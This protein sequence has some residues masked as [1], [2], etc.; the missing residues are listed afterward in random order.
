MVYH[1][2][3]PEGVL[4]DHLKS[5][6][7][8]PFVQE[9]LALVD[10]LDV[11]VLV[12][13]FREDGSG[14]RPYDPYLMAVS[15]V[16]CFRNGI[17]QPERMAE[18]C[19][20]RTQLL[21][22]W[23]GGRTPKAS[24][25]RRFIT[26]RKPAWQSIEV[27]VLRACGNA[28]LLDPSITATDSSPMD[29]PASLRAIRSLPRIR[30]AISQT[31]QELE[32]LAIITERT[33]QDL[34]PR[35]DLDLLI[36][37]VCGTLAQQEQKLR[38]RLA[39]LR[40]AEAVAEQRM[41]ESTTRPPPIVTWINKIK[42]H[43]EELQRMI[44]D[45]N[46]RIAEHAARPGRRRGSLLP[47]EQ[48]ARVK[49]KQDELENAQARLA[50]AHSKPSP[51]GHQPR[52]NL[53]EPGSWLLLG[54]NTTTWVQGHLAMLTVTSAQI[55][56][57]ARFH[58]GG[59]D[60]GGLHPSLLTAADNCRLAG[61]TTPMRAH[62]ADAG[63]ASTATFT[64]PTP[65]GGTLYV[66]VTNEAKQTSPEPGQK[67]PKLPKGHQEMANRMATP[68]GKALYKRRAQMVEPVFSHLFTRGGRHLHTRGPAAEIELIIMASTHN[69]T[70]YIRHR[71]RNH[72][73]Q[74][75]R[76]PLPTA[77]EDQPPTIHQTDK[78]IR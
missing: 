6:L 50:E 43:E 71:S 25:F 74:Q 7:E 62:L 49:K 31:Q 55:V 23:G 16:W 28:G 67:P 8:D 65:T 14:G 61:V 35:E 34:D 27:D 68:Q 36:D 22:L 73:K 41:Q 58:H 32:E 38:N 2:L 26:G 17:R 52:A 9:L 40:Q 57:S 54:K 42:K 59:N 19:R 66:S 44:A 11:S 3:G 12:A 4:P 30:L 47:P 63:F 76:K 45:Q 69:G 70:K 51:R 33:F 53:T 56:L 37:Q 29:S 72:H 20:T 77:H 18:E 39:K 15:T 46:R 21:A 1:F 5:A 10:Q 75:P 64:T 60:Q 78:T 24:T 48:L 13:G